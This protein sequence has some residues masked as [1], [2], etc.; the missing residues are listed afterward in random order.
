MPY[1]GMGMEISAWLAQGARAVWGAPLILFISAFGIMMTLRL[2]CLQIRALPRAL[3]LL[4]APPDGAKGAVSAFGAL[5]TSLA[6]MIGTG[7]IVGVATA[8]AAGGP[9]AVFWML[10][11]AFFG[12]ITSYAEG[13]LA[14]KY[15]RVGADG[16]V[17][18]GAFLYIER[19]MGRKFR[20]LAR[21]FAVCGALAALLG[22]GTMAQV[23]GITGAFCDLFDPRGAWTLTLGGVTL[24]GGALAVAVVVTLVTGLII[25]GGI[26]RIAKA[27]TVVVPV[28]GAL[29]V[30]GTLGVLIAC[31]PRLPGALGAI[32][33]GA[34]SPDA[35][36]GGAAGTMAASA[37]RM[38]VSRG[39]F[40]NE[41]GLGSSSIAAAAA[42]T[43]S[44]VEQGLCTMTGTFIDTIVLCTM[45]GLA[46]VVTGAHES[47]L[48]G[49][50][51]TNLAYNRG[52]SMLPGMGKLIVS[53]ALML[54]ATASILGWNYYGEQCVEYLAGR[55]MIP[56]YRAAY[57]AAVFFGA[58][59]AVD[60]VWNLADILNGLMAFPNLIA[61]YALSGVVLRE[62]R[63]YFSSK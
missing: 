48:S 46:I 61:L 30:L 41:A 23:N 49:V 33:R 8:V 14:V 47:G 28:M 6:A 60:T 19:G 50:A 34:F 26:E 24:S 25:C 38:G 18:G 11:A 37:I 4:F 13:L 44:P 21:L 16:R 51:L 42:K 3:R 27:S 36:L 40:S 56:L 22:I 35:A 12:M 32:V 55:R 7:N 53:T 2:R 43:Q 52:L 15:R 39:I 59:F 58:F 9:G 57:L 63:R 62:S 45:T 54:F 17:L 10:V 29:Y 5:S 1:G 20:P 31:A